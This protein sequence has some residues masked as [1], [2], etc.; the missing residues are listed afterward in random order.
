MARRQGPGEGGRELAGRY[1]RQVEQGGMPAQTYW[2]SPSK[3][4]SEEALE[5]VVGRF[6]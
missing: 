3:E 4:E 2:L 1:S 6:F 5:D